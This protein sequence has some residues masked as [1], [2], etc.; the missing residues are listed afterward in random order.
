VESFLKDLKLAYK[1]TSIS[2]FLG[3]NVAHQFRL[4]NQKNDLRKLNVAEVESSFFN[5][6]KCVIFIDHEALPTIEFGKNSMQPSEQVLES[7]EEISLDNRNT[8]IVYSHQSRKVLEETFSSIENLCLCAESGYLYKMRSSSDWI[9]LM[10]LA[11][12]VWLS[13]VQEIMMNYTEN[14]DGSFVEER[15]STLVWNYKNAE[16][17]QGSMVVKE[18]YN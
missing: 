16:E 1:P 12:K 15:E 13:L 7:I 14:V 9:K 5:S 18:L 6:N 11:N 10:H 3:I 17:E 4:I 2:Y 8:V